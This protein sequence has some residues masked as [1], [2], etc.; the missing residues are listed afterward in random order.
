VLK[1]MQIMSEKGLVRRDERAR[2][3]IYRASRP[4][5]WTQRQIA[6]DL[7]QRAFGGSAASMVM[8]A[9]AARKAS[10]EDLKEIRKLLDEYEKGNK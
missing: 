7:L 5:E 1:F 4:Q 9:L 6:G 3:H 2:A 8:G 10:A